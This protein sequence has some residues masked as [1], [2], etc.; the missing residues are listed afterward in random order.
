[1]CGD[2]Q[3]QFYQNT[4]IAEEMVYQTTGGMADVSGAGI[5]VNIIPSGAQHVQRSVS[6]WARSARGNPT[7]SR[8]I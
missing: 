3:V 2:G 5:S 6:A 8:R 1:M 7:T 4:A